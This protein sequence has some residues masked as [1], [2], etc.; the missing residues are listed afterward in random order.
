VCLCVSVCVCHSDAT[1]RELAKENARAK[2]EIAQKLAQTT[3]ELA[4]MADKKAMLDAET[5]GQQQELVELRRRV[6]AFE[7]QVASMTP[8]VEH[9]AVCDELAATARERLELQEALT[10]LQGEHSEAQVAAAELTENYNVIRTEFKLLLSQPQFKN[11]RVNN[12]ISRL[13][14]DAGAPRGEAP[15]AVNSPTATGAKAK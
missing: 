9:D 14:N 12:K 10:E 6:A 2:K 3:R 7:K 5:G 8:T 11:I 4:E 1:A 15:S 13:L